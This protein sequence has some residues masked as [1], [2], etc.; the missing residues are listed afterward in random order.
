MHAMKK[1]AWRRRVSL[2]FLPM[3]QKATFPSISGLNG[4]LTLGI[5]ADFTHPPPRPKA[6][7]APQESNMAE[8]AVHALGPGG[9]P[10]DMLDF[11]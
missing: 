10:A 3:K 11:L 1:K 7:A 9:P 2:S 6:Q 4:P 5:P 8:G